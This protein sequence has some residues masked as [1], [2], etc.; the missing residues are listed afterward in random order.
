MPPKQKPFA[1]IGDV[2]KHREDYRAHVQ[3]R[4]EAGVKRDIRGP[5]RCYKGLRVGRAAWA[6]A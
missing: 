1:S 2:E 3:Y 4:D 5:D 6:Q